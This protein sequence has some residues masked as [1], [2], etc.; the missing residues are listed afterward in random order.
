MMNIYF[1]IISSSPSKQTRALSFYYFIYAHPWNTHNTPLI[2]RKVNCNNNNNKF[3]CKQSVLIAAAFIAYW[4]ILKE[5][6]LHTN[7]YATSYV[8]IVK[9]NCPKQKSKCEFQSILHNIMRR[10]NGWGIRRPSSLH[11][12]SVAWHCSWVATR[13]TVHW[14]SAVPRHAHAGTCCQ[15][16]LR[17]IED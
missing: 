4:Q 2:V 17:F 13:Y 11:G 3:N 1:L 10:T 7:N 12:N 8:S 16:Q 14:T 6:R 5:I 15:H 9:Q